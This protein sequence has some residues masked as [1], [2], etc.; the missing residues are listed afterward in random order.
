MKYQIGLSI[1][2]LVFTGCLKVAKKGEA[3]KETK[4][5]TISTQAES[6]IEALIKS[7]RRRSDYLSRRI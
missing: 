2:V 1:L 4:D 6:T 7:S 3:E 5:R